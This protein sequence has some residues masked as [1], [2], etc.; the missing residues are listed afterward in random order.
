M[1]VDKNAKIF[2]VEDEKKRWRSHRAVCREVHLLSNPCD[3]RPESH[4][5]FLRGGVIRAKKRGGVESL[6]GAQS[7]EVFGLRRTD[8][9]EQRGERER[10]VRTAI[11]RALKAEEIAVGELRAE[12]RKEQEQLA[13]DLLNDARKLLEAQQPY[14]AVARAV[15]KEYGLK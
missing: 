13:T 4:L 15:F 12:R 8:L 2:P 3:D 6:R 9:V 5:E 11:E 1:Q 14:L 10:L 7:I